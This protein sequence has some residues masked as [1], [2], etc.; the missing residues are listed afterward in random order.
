MTCTAKVHG[1]LL[2]IKYENSVSQSVLRPDLDTTRPKLNCASQ[3]VVC[4][5]SYWTL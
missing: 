4:S 5:L 2:A 3:Q 1:D